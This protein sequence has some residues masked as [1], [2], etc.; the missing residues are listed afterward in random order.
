MDDLIKRTDAIDAIDVLKRNYPSSCFE[1]L[2]KAVDIAIKALSA[3]QWIPVRC[4][5]CEF[6]KGSVCDYSAVYVRDN[7]FCSWGKQQWILI[8]ERL[9]TKEEYIANN[10]LFIVS[11]GDRT[12][13]EYFDIYNSMQY[14]GEPTMNGFRVDKC[15][16]KWMPLPE[17]YR[18]EKQISRWS[19]P[20]E[21]HAYE[22]GYIEGRAE[23]MQYLSEGLIRRSDAVQAIAEHLGIPVK[24]WAKVA[25]GW[26]ADVQDVK[27]EAHKS[28]D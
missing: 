10:G 1:D 13:A 26:L 6:R 16:I 9:P 18:K 4:H 8:T 27:A 3:Q 7:G 5:E 12:Y 17:S 22:T 25:E 15:V 11:D 14:F 24:Y 23:V 19:T 21:A 2:C 28:G 20:G